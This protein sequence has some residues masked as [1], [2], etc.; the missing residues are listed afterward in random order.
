MD[1]ISFYMPTKV[2]FGR[3]CIR[4]HMDELTRLGSRALIVTDKIAS[5]LNGSEKDVVEILEQA[6]ITFEIFEDVEANPTIGVVRAGL[7]RCEAFQ[8]DFLIAIGGGSPMDTAKA[9]SVLARQ[10][11]SDDVLFSTTLRDDVLPLVCVPTTAGTGSEV[12]PYAMVIDEKTG[13]KNNLNSPYMFAKV[14]FLDPQYTM[15]L[16]LRGTINTAIDAMTHA[17]ESIWAVTTNPLVQSMAWEAVAHIAKAFPHMHEGCLTEEDRGHLMLGSV[18]GGMVV[19]QTRTTAL[20][21]MSYPMTS[22]AHIP[23]GRA[24]C[25]ILSNYVRFWQRYEPEMVERLLG[26]MCLADVN[27]FEKM[28]DYFLGRKERLTEE[29]IQAYADEVMGK[30]NIQN[31]RAPIT[32]DDVVAIYHY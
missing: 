26:L 27:A 14:A 20:H 28:M 2:F 6:G 5:K 17:L 10:P 11:L 32:R 9:I 3:N 4:G 21:G 18:M 7:A 29:Q 24:M 23:H 8:A 22:H 16:P 1:P 25:L 15:T 31:T 13:V 19:S 12:T 30:H